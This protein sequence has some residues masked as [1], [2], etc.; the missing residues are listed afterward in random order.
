MPS[1]WITFATNATK[2]LTE[3]KSKGIIETA[4]FITNEY[5]NSISTSA[6]LTS[7]P[8]IVSTINKIKMQNAIISAFTTQFNSKDKIGLPTYTEIATGIIDMWK[9][10][11]FTTSTLS[12]YGNST[13]FGMALQQAFLG[14]ETE[15]NINIAINNV[16]TKLITAFKQHMLSIVGTTNTANGTVPFVGIN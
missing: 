3:S 6:T 11:K 10:I 13:L 9:Q 7:M 16:V 15:T 14:Q 1:N 5:V 12:V 4:E 2:F 8:I